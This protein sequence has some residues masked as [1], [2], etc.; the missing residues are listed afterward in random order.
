MS[1]TTLRSRRESREDLDADG[2]IDKEVR[3]GL[4]YRGRYTLRDDWAL[5]G[6]QWGLNTDALSVDPVF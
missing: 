6:K 5:V 1:S 4:S 2:L 3:Q